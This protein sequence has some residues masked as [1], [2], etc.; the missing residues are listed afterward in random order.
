MAVHIVADSTCDLSAELIARYQI[1]ILPLYVMLGDEEHRDG[2]TIHAADI[3]QYVDRGGVL[4]KTAAV[5][6]T[7]FTACFEEILTAHPEDEIL[8]LTIGQKFSSCYQNAVIAAGETGHTVV[9]DSCNLSSG[10]G[11]VVLSAAELAAEG[12]SA[13]EI[14]DMLQK[15]I[16]PYVEASFLV[17]RLDYLRMGGRCS[18]VAVLGANLLKLKP[19]IEV[20]NGEMIVAKKY[21]G[22]FERCVTQYAQERLADRAQIRSRRIFITHAAADASAVAAA[23]AA[24]EAAGGFAEITETHAGCTVSSH[25]GPN[26]LGILFIRNAT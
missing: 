9:V 3:F 12:H 25:C 24:I 18:G 22:T 11:H 17:D 10:F 4:P 13:A 20:R 5:A 8:C 19:C 21:R 23:K 2:V 6:V 1:T 15:D 26:T 7:D 14:S 16:I